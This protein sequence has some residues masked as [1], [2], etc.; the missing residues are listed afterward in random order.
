MARLSVRSGDI[1]PSPVRD[2]LNVS[3]RPGMISF[4]GGLP[5]PETFAGLDLP[6]PP[7]DLLQYGPTEGEPALRERIAQ[8]L[9][10]LGL[11]TDADR[12]LVLSGSQQGIDLAAKLVVDAGVTLAVESPAY[13]AALQVFRFYGARFEIIDRSAPGGSWADAPP[14][15]AYVIP[16][17]QNPSGHCWSAAERE[18]MAKA[19]LANDV[20]LFEDDPYRDLVY[21]P[22]D[23]TPVSAGMAGGS[24]IYQGSF[25]KTVAPGL[26]LGYLTASPDLFPLLVQLKQAADLH[27]NRLSQWMVLQYLNDPGRAERMA[28]VAA[29][30]RGKRDAFADALTRHLGNLAS[31]SLPPG[32]LFFWLTLADGTDVEA[33]LKK[34][35]ER[36]VLFTPGS[37]FLAEGGASPTIRLN[38]S[39]A[40]PEAAERGLAVL[41]ELLRG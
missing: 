6:P 14:S 29:L 36:G 32:G 7:R 4:A 39:L 38:F 35:V 33:L 10:A 11:D 24:W 15:M 22:S 31:W 23:R 41:A 13:L 16:T 21:E 3:Q 18:A 34:A 1:K 30:Y 2:M 26:R 28:Q 8:D 37:H 12:I 25:S 27:T 9:V 19:C 17:F 40:E 20:I 5:S